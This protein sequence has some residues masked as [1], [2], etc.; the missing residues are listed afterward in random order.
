LAL[1]TCL[2]EA[3]LPAQLT[4][5]DG[6]EAQIG[7]VEG[8][9]VLAR[10][11]EQWTELLEG[12]AGEVNPTNHDAFMD[13]EM[14]PLTS[15]LAPALWVDGNDH[16]ATW[17][18][19]LES[20]GYTNPT[21]DP[22]VDPKVDRIW[23]QRYADAA[24]YWIACAREHGLPQLADTTPDGDDGP[25]GPHA[26]IPLNT[27]PDLLRTVVEACPIFKEDLV[28]RQVEGDVTL[29]DDIFEGRIA[30]IPLVLVE[31]PRGMQEAAN[32]EEGFDFKSGEGKRYL[33]LQGILYEAGQAFEEKYGREQAEKEAAGE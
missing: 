5:V 10:D 26:E 8:H 17:T 24:N 1:E 15:D 29:Q 18:K 23:A 33:E 4:P 14:D 13:V 6:G 20:S 19:C 16:T 22:E 21:A 11:F 7:W 30:P 12:P 31:E 3:G 2:V 28:R 27:G 32:T 25:Y 9:E